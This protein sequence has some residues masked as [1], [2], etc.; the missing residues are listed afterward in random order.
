MSL[1]DFFDSCRYWSE[2]RNPLLNK[3]KFYSVI[4]VLAARI[5]NIVLPLYFKLTKNNENYKLQSDKQEGERIIVS[6]TSFPKRLPKLHLV[7]EC[8]LRGQVKPDKI[9]L[10]LSEN[11]VPNM[12]AVPQELRDLQ[13]RGLEI[14]I[15]P[16]D[17]RS[18][19]KYFYAFQEFPEDTVITVDDDMFYRSDLLSSMLKAHG[20][21]PG[22]IIANWT[23]TIVPGKEKYTEWT[24]TTELKGK[25]LL[26]IG[27]GGVL[28]PPHCMYKDVFD[29]EKIKGM[30]FTADDIWLTAMAMMNKTLLHNPDYTTHFLPVIIKDN[31]SL[32]ANNYTLNQKCIDNINEYYQKE[33]GYRPF[34][35]IPMERV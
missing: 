16:D 14:Y 30:V 10:Y 11:Q 13:A 17:L 4:N 19:K 1:V 33:L 22:K 7:I 29:V 12:D 6:L 3:I 34:I 24:D 2:K 21:N 28:Y 25:Y 26:L 20:E 8:L 32:L 23:K 27:V 18:H 15:K 35:D 31:T 5:A 9:V